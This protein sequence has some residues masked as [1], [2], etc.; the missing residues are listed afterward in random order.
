[1]GRE[2]CPGG[3]GFIVPV[4]PSPI[5]FLEYLE[6]HST[7]GAFR[8]RKDTTLFYKRHLDTSDGG[9]LTSQKLEGKK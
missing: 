2:V 6:N 1:M 4:P 9:G 3:A 5:L 8:F 7:L